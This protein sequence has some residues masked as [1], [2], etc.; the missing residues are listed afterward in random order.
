MTILNEQTFDNFISNGKVVV[1]FSAS[2][3]GP[4]R[5]L[6]PVLEQAESSHEG[7]IAKVDIDESASIAAKYGIRSIPTTVSFENGLPIDRKIGVISQ[8]DIMLLLN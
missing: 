2:W 5:V 4:C 8:N 1:N 6:A 7:K 3:C